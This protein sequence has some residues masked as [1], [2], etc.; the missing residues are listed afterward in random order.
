MR[1]PLSHLTWPLHAAPSERERLRA[2]AVLAASDRD[3][4]DSVARA[5]GWERRLDRALGA[6]ERPTRLRH[7]LVL[8]ELAQKQVFGATELEV[9]AD[10]SSMWFVD[11]LIAPRQIDGEVD[12]RLRGSIAH[13][14][15]NKF[16]SGLPKRSA[17][18]ASRPRSSPTRCGS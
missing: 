3:E 12:A 9:F 13:S 4:A 2:L 5:N 1:R 15:L 11:R 14:A 18:S 6:S 10:C 17:P 8:E 16:Y 7:P